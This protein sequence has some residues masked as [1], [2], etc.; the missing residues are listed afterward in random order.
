VGHAAALAIRAFGSGDPA[1]TV[2][3][4]RPIRNHAQRF[5]GSHA[6]RDLIDLTLIEAATRAGQDRLAAALRA[7]R[8]AARRETPLQS[9]SGRGCSASP[10]PVARTAFA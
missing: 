8:D 3:L 5:G 4:L 9:L 10:R 6:Q 7:E 1:A 2:R